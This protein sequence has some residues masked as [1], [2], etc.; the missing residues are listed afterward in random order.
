MDDPLPVGTA[1]DAPLVE[2]WLQCERRAWLEVRAPE[3]G[4][5]SD[6]LTRYLAAQRADLRSLLPVVLG[7]GEAPRVPPPRPARLRRTPRAVRENAGPCFDPALGAP[8]ASL[9]PAATRHPIQVVAA[10]DAL[11]SDEDGVELIV[12]ANGTRVRDHHVRGLALASLLAAHH[13]IATR[14]ATVLHVDRR[15][16]AAAPH[17]LLAGADVTDRCLTQRARLPRRLVAVAASLRAPHEPATATGA[18]CLHPRR[19][20]FYERCWAPATTPPVDGVEGLR[21]ST[22]R[23]W[24]SAG[25]HTLADVPADVPGLTPAEREAV[26]DA[27]IARPRIRHG[28]L[29]E[30]LARLVHPVAYLDIEFATPALPMLEDTAP[31]ETLPF[32][33]SVHVEAADG[34]VR[35]VDH[36]VGDPATE[37]RGALAGRLADVLGDTGSVVVYDAASERR[38]LRLL[39]NRVDGAA[40]A[41]LGAAAGR[42]WDLLAVVQASVRHPGFGARWSLK[43]VAATLAAS[44]YDEVRLSDGLTAQAE[45]RR[46]LRSHDPVAQE[47][48]RRYC[49]ADSHAMLE[50]V[51]VLR[52]WR[53]DPP[54]RGA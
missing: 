43:R 50:I 51:R 22:R 24:R 53:R 30:A 41:R 12:L 25:W 9:V 15:G 31:F 28:N 3:L 2:A 38:L 54:G 49:D 11:R 39:Q 42:L 37:P 23:A 33:F 35:H 10:F 19:C 7:G 26:G 47:A 18:H 29:D 48:L 44:S 52:A 21:P 1:I 46:W 4:N 20:P 34:S 5:R 8:L 32:Q 17:T 36:L 14:R 40:A 13:G 27:R 45:W 16:R 6:G